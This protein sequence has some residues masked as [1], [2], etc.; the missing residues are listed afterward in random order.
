MANLSFCSTMTDPAVTI[1]LLSSV[2]LVSL[3]SASS[4]F[5]IA[6][7][8]PSS[9][10]LAAGDIPTKTAA[11]ARDV[12]IFFMKILS[13]SLG[14]QGLA[15]GVA[16]AIFLKV[17]WRTRNSL[18]GLESSVGAGSRISILAPDCQIVYLQ[19]CWSSRGVKE[20]DTIS[21]STPLPKQSRP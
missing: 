4:F 21:H 20:N 14:L 15:C 13:W 18:E 5:W 10:A 11:M 1:S 17:V 6:A 19:F 16:W 2:G 8:P 3:Y 9:Q 7:L 12:A